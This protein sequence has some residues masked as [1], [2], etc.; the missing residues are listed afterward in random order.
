M[1][2]SSFSKLGTI[3]GRGRNGCVSFTG[4]YRA[5]GS[6]FEVSKPF[7]VVVKR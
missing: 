6:L 2:P 3:V 1:C 4:S 5:S 7:K